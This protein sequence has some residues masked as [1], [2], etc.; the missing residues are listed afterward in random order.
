M[1][2]N[3]RNKRSRKSV[4]PQQISIFGG[5][6]TPCM[7]S[8]Q[9]NSKSGNQITTGGLKG[10]RRNKELIASSVD[11]IFCVIL[12]FIFLQIL[13]CDLNLHIRPVYVMRYHPILI[14]SKIDKIY[15][16]LLEMKKRKKMEN[17]WMLQTGDASIVSLQD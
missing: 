5:R 10:F 9:F 4:K 13:R 1:D 17:V 8:L 14:R 16:N 12:Y 15:K 2:R 7:N 6:V 11:F 3:R